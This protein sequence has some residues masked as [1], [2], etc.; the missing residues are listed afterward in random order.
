MDNKKSRLG[1][2]HLM[3]LCL[4]A[5]QLL[6]S[7]THKSK[8]SHHFTCL[9]GEK[10]TVKLRKNKARDVIKMQHEMKHLHTHTH[11]HTLF[12]EFLRLM[13][14]FLPQKAWKIL[15]MYFISEHKILLQ[16]CVCKFIHIHKVTHLVKPYS[17]PKAVK[18]LQF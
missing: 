2:G 13:E 14:S 11:T 9:K 3:S 17:H 7:P 5:L 12:I 15:P 4:P 1:A 18:R 10:E 16:T 6:N 8:I